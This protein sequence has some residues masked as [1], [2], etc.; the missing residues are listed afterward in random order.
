MNQSTQ[1]LLKLQ[2]ADYEFSEE[3]Q[4]KV[5]FFYE[6][7]ASLIEL[8]LERYTISKEGVVYKKLLDFYNSS[9]LT[10]VRGLGALVKGKE[11]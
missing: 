4:Q 5:Y 2:L 7:G 9:F 1:A 10:L 8:L 6:S 3:V 11:D